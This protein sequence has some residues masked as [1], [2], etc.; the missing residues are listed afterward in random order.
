MIIFTVSACAKGKYYPSVEITDYEKE[1]FDDKTCEELYLGY[2][3]EDKEKISIILNTLE[4]AMS[5]IGDPKKA[6]KEYGVLCS[7]AH[8]SYYCEKEEHNY[9]IISIDLKEEEGKGFLWIR[10]S[11]A[12]I[13][14]DGSEGESS[15][16][17]KVKIGLLLKNNE[18]IAD[19]VFRTP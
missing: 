3:E 19:Y 11:D 9:S 7:F 10:Y 12:E 17:E 16:D 8:D 4:E 18:W 13:E 15:T 14:H 5:F 1:C 2:S 6:K